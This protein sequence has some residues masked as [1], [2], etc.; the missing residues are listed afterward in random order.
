MKRHLLPIY[1]FV[2]YESVGKSLIH[3]AITCHI[4]RIDLGLRMLLILLPRH[5]RLILW[6]VPVVNPATFTL[7]VPTSSGT[8]IGTCRATDN[9]TSW[10][11]TW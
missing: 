3:L 8:L 4:S 10:A 2:G 1:P 9:P 5:H 11:I 7:L 6:K